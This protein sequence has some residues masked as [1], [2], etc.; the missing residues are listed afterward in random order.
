LRTV[1]LSD[2]APGRHNPPVPALDDL[3][4]RLA[5]RTLQLV[6]VPSESRCE[7]ELAAL[8]GAEMP[9]APT[10]RDEETLW[11]DASAGAAPLVVLAGHLDTVPAQGNLP[12]RLEDGRVVG[13]G[14][15]DMKGGLAVMVELARWLA[16][17]GAETALDLGFLFFPREEIAVEES[18]LPRLFETGLLERA[19]LVVVL[20]P[21]DNTIQAGCVGNLNA[22]LTF[23][24]VSAHSA[25]PWLG[26]NAIARAVEALVPIVRLEPVDVEVQGLL[27]R[28]TVTVTEIEGG[29]AAN[30]VPAAASCT[31]NLRYA[32]GTTGEQALARVRALLAD[33]VEVEVLSDSAPAHVALDNPLVERLRAAGDFAV[34]PKQAWT[35]VAQFAERGLDAVNLGP[36]ATRFAHKAD[37]QVEAAELA[38]TFEALRRFVEG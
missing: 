16:A 12:G 30:V 28:D 4:D 5:R 38:R 22:R 21:T 1:T 33:D 17:S 9:W 32:P 25:R 7:Q 8:V 27:F 11:F 6:D 18:P 34:E 20:E 13:L 10:W 36:G 23:R 3:A 26:V 2:Y 15:S 19:G 24:G 29:I 37:E 31:L 35:P 14:A